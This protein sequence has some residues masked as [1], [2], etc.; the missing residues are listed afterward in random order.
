MHDPAEDAGRLFAE[1]ETRTPH[2]SLELPEQIAELRRLFPVTERWVYM[3]HAAIGPLPQ[4]AAEALAGLAH[5]VAATGDALWPER[6]QECE[7]VRGLAARLLGAREAHEVAFTANT[8]DALSLVA[9]GLAWSPGDNVVGAACEFPSN[10]YPWMRLSERGVEYRQVA[11][12]EGRLDLEELISR[13]DGR[14]RV[15]ALSWVQ[16][17]NGFRADLER[18]GKVCRERGVL[19][20][21]DAIQGLGALELDVERCSIDV[22]AAATHKWL[23]GPEGLGLL[24]IADRVVAQIRPARVGWRSTAAPFDWDR[25]DLTPAPGA[26]RH[27]SGTLPVYPIHAL[28]ASLELLHALGPERVERRVL[29]L[30]GRLADGLEERGLRVVSSR[31]DGERSGIVAAVHPRLPAD[32]AVRALEQQRIRVAERA[33]RLRIAPHVYNTEDEVDRL[34]AV[35]DG[36]G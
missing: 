35:L 5:D 6:N 22:C 1:A 3:N 31:R 28:G 19:F 13:I 26:K 36:L 14:T 33:G 9:E 23:L 16:Y 11:E 24:Y 21:V 29:A 20:V 25:F 34:L 17:G 15:L 4:P 7:R 8:S 12:R 32:A 10:V 27:E 2:A 30:A 18:L